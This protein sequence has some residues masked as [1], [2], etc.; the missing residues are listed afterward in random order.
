VFAC[1]DEV[2]NREAWNNNPLV[3]S[4]G[5]FCVHIREY[6]QVMEDIVLRRKLPHPMLKEFSWLRELQTA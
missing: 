6:P 3:S 5:T 1:F 4:V 2:R